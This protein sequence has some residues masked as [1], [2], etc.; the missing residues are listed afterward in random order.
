MLGWIPA[1]YQGAIFWSAVTL[2]VLAVGAIL[3]V[4]SGLYSVAAS[5]DHF[6]VTTRLLD[7]GLRRSVATH[8]LGISAPPLDDMDLVRVGAGHY[9]GGC[10]PCHGAPGARKSPTVANMLPPPPRLSRAVSTWSPPELFWIVR[11]GLKYTGM[12]A[13]PAYR[14]ADEVWAVVAFLRKLPNMEGAEY[15]ALATGHAQAR[16][17]TAQELTRLGSGQAAV[18]AC[19]RC[20]GDEAAE[21]TSR[22]VPRLA[23][24][25]EGYLEMALRQYADGSRPSGI[26]GP[27]A[28][29]LD[30]EAIARLSQYYARLPM[31]REP[32]P[33]EDVPSGGIQR[34]EAI[35]LRGVP[36]SGIPSCL[37]CHSGTAPTFP[38]LAG[39]Y[40]AY[41][42]GQLRLFRSGIRRSTTHAAIMAPIARR[43]TDR[44]ITDVAAYFESLAPKPSPAS[45]ASNST[46]AP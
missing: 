26:M 25:S 40:S 23:G 45:N 17:R 37:S 11:N 6:A 4:V 9:Y 3:F 29:E 14:R 32:V 44:Q 34:G 46:G 18:S 19:V 5:S 15:R 10:A 38:K 1:Q 8:S 22:L 7:F 41:T 33:S 20:H 36:A 12:P 16:P 43:L 31:G 35:A 42:A 13:W 28:A 27:L 2:A 24:Q 21:P 30:A 39:Q